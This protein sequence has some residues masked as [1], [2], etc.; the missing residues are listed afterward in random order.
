MF[1]T[2]TKDTGYS[3]R[4]PEMLRAIR[5]AVTLPIVAIGGI[6][7]G[8]VAQT[9]QA[10]ADSA[11]IISDILGAEHISAK[12]ARILGAAPPYFTEP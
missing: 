5:A 2:A 12:V 6:N 4:G 7:E 10:G 8:N 11:A 1:A 3:A 9:W